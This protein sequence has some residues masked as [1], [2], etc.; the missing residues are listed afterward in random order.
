MNDKIFKIDDKQ[1]R[2]WATEETLRRLWSESTTTN[3]LLA[4]MIRKTV[5]DDQVNAIL[6]GNRAAQ[7][8]YDKVASSVDRASQRNTD[9]LRDTSESLRKGIT[10]TFKDLGKSLGGMAM[11]GDWGSLEYNLKSSS[12][13]LLD[14]R[15]E[16]IKSGAGISKMGLSLMSFA[17]N[18]ALFGSALAVAWDVLLE[19]NKSFNGLY[20]VGI[21]LRGG[22][23]SLTGISTDLGMTVV[24]TTRILS[25]FSETVTL[26][27]SDRAKGLALEFRKLTRDGAQFGMST[28]EATAAALSYA[29]MLRSSGVLATMS[30]PELAAG[31]KEFQT[32]LSIAS[33]VTG[34][35]RKEME[36]DIR[37][38]MQDARAAAAMA[39]IPENMRK[40]MQPTLAQFMQLGDAGKMVGEN[41]L[42][43][44]A[45]GDQMMD[46]NF[47][48]TMAI[49]GATAEFNDMLA[50]GIEKGNVSAQTYEAFASKFSQMSED[51]L[52]NLLNQAVLNGSIT[53]EAAQ[54]ALELR[55]GAVN[56]AASQ[57]ELRK[58]AIKNLNG[59]KDENK[60]TA[61][62]AKLRLVR[63]K[64]SAAANA[65][66]TAASESLKRASAA[67]STTFQSL[68]V[69]VLEP[70]LPALELFGKIVEGIASKFK[71]F[72][73]AIGEFIRWLANTSVG[74]AMGM[75]TG[76]PEERNKKG[77][78]V[79][80][81]EKDWTDTAGSLA[82]VGAAAATLYGGKRLLKRRRAGK[83]KG[84]DGLPIPETPTP[85]SPPGSALAESIGD[86]ATDLISKKPGAA[87]LGS[88]AL[89]L[90][91]TGLKVGGLGGVISGLS[92]Y[93][94]S[95]NLLKSLL[96]GGGSALGGFIGGAAG[97]AVAPGLGTAAGG[98]G[99]AYAGEAA[100]EW[101]YKKI[102]GETKSGSTPVVEPVT[103]SLQQQTENLTTAV[104]QV[105]E[106]TNAIKSGISS[107]ELANATL[108]FYNTAKEDNLSIM[109][110]LVNMND[111][112]ERIEQATRDQTSE[113]SRD[114]GG[115]GRVY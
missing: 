36:K 43:V 22:L 89:G 84:K 59:E 76:A 75:T 5:G 102:A 30:V 63:E 80:E 1:A 65:K 100:G 27:G 57:A 108:N 33:Q 109:N 88:K 19:V 40:N 2:S 20:D 11:K 38:R 17:G 58:Q 66:A 96:V 99:G 68:V 69:N 28:V 41:F 25:E 50:E 44:A 14:F 53:K 8:G 35:S 67:L 90:A 31:A 81:R 111:R 6:S 93:G 52:R 98:I 56:Y 48:T 37:A 79:R 86:I 101:L 51:T 12:K 77:E 92:E 23:S 112:L 71:S 26:L 60:I 32:Q 47:R 54:Y 85:P 55:K 104:N 97:T 42:N 82:T 45:N 62:M 15:K 73:D 34:K 16:A 103:K 18:A 4:S 13:S 110:L 46:R 10:G 113:L 49:T 107:D 24:D 106:S 9:V 74:K 72:S 39:L 83:G 70:L 94:E 64:E 115:I 3:R 114:I 78:I 29:E 21:N 95:G 91:K 7:R 105:T 87:G 61:E